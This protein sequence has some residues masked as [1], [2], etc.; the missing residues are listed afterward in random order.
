VVEIQSFLGTVGYCQKFI[1][2]FSKICE[3]LY[4]LT[5]KDK[6]WLWTKECQQ[7]FDDIKLEFT[8]APVLAIPDSSKPMRIDCDASQTAIGA[9]LFVK[10]EDEQWHPCSFMSHKLI[11]AERNYDTFN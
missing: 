6:P 9:V 8:R 4:N 10:L 1:K 3:P 11:A 2:N 7:S 5:K